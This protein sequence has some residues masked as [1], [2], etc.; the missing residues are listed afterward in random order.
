MKPIKAHVTRAIP[1]NSTIKVAD[2]SGARL[3]TVISIRGYKGVKNRYPAGGV[4]DIITAV[5]KDG[6]P[7]MK[8]KIVNAVIIR[9][10]KE[11]RR[12]NGLRVKFEDNAAIL[13]KDLK[14]KDPQATIVKGPIAKEVIERFPN[15][16]KVASIVA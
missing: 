15:I 12:A 5:V 14:T 1:V 3:I 2:N 4:G 8:H 6:T 13:L 11:Y 9:Q 16:S 10:K 7:E